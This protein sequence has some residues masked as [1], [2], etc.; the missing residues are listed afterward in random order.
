MSDHVRAALGLI[1][2]GRTLTLEPVAQRVAVDVC[3]IRGQSLAPE[4]VVIRV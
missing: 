1:V 2:E 3:E 4:E